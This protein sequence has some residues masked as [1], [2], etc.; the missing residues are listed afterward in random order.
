MA[1][2]Y[3]LLKTEPDCFSIDD[4]Q[5]AP[6]RISSWDGVRNY[7]AR[8]IL[9][10][11][12]KAGDE[13][14]FYHSSANPT[15]VAGLCTIVRAG[16]PDHTAWDPTSE[17]FDPKAG[18]NNPIWYMIDVKFK[19]KLREVLPLSALKHTPG[20]E[21]MMVVQRGSRL[22]VQPV[23]NEEWKI[24]LTLMKQYE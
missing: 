23:T 3:W 12:V 20:L 15:G 21:Q 11:D 6:G 13:A 4:L 14:L 9:R 1:K 10:D 7:Q 24:V 22:S 18:P 8:N 17:H 16:Y 5:A 2:R 19:K